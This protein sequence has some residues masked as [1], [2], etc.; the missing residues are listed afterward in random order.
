MENIIKW[1]TGTPNYNG[2]YLITFRYFDYN[3]KYVTIA[4]RKDNSW[5][6]TDYA[7][8]IVDVLAWYPIANIKPYEETCNKD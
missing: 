6:S 2:T 1:Q 4:I 7:I 5:Y 8:L 3:P